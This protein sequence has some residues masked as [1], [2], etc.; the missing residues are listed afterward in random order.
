M[1]DIVLV[2][3]ITR[4]GK[5]GESNVGAVVSFSGKLSR[6][7]SSGGTRVR[8]KDGLMVAGVILVSLDVV[9]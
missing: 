2:V 3:Q 8:S 5:E 7:G 6:G 9:L 1:E 4:S